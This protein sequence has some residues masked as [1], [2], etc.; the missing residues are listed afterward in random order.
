V[1]RGKSGGWRHVLDQLEGVPRITENIVKQGLAALEASGHYGRIV[2]EAK[3][4]REGS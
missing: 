3:T 2:R 4:A 1:E